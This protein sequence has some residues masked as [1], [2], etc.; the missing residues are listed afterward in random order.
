MDDAIDFGPTGQIRSAP[1]QGGYYAAPVRIKQE[2]VN[3]FLFLLATCP[4]PGSE[5]APRNPGQIINAP[6]LKVFNG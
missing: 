5:F 1:A 3:L 2:P 4:R 6:L